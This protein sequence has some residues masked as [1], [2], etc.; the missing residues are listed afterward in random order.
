MI[1][2]LS[3]VL[4]VALW[5]SWVAAQS[6]CPDMVE[7]VLETTAS[8]CENTGDNQVCYGAGVLEAEPQA[9]V[10]D[11]E[12]AASGDLVGAED[13]QTLRLAND[14]WSVALVR[15]QAGLTDQNVQ[16]LAFGDVEIRNAI[17]TNPE[18]LT[19]QVTAN[20]GANIRSI[21][22]TQAGILGSLGSGET[23]IADGR[24]EDS[25]WIRV[26]VSGEARPGWVFAELLSAD[27][28][29]DTL[30]IADPSATAYD[31]MQAFYFESGADDAPCADAPDS[32]ILIQSPERAGRVTLLVNEVEI[33]LGLTVYLQTD[34]DGDLLINVLEGSVWV[35]SDGDGQFVPA[36][37]RVRIPLDD[38]AASGAP[39][40]PEPY[41]DDRIAAL[42]VSVLD[43]EI[44]IVPAL[45]Q[46]AI[47]AL[48]GGILPT[49]GTWEFVEGDCGEGHTVNIDVTN[50]GTAF[51]LTDT[52]TGQHG[53]YR[54]VEPGVFV[55]SGFYRVN[56]I[57]EAFIH[58]ESLTGDCAYAD[59]ILANAS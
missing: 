56:V 11:F 43:R 18:P 57:S 15:L 53:T 58:G 42:P 44:E 4:L 20:T 48:A 55:L 23:I 49:E 40:K 31:A 9:E 36:G 59:Y 21:P 5:V 12:F 6:D 33:R 37:A 47:D 3:V 14:E 32:G 51:V 1:R 29:L 30:G 45:T 24:L 16:L 35:E 26:R 46:A 2:K 25:S 34:S 41:D 7:E 22:S 17:E 54:R 10:D 28:A 50:D 52:V 27:V 19:M 38:G 39:L 13:V 8:V